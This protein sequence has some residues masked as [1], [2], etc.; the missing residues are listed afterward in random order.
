MRADPSTWVVIPSRLNSTRLPQKALHL[1]AGKP[2]IVRVVE[3]ALQSRR[4]EKVIVA[5]DH[6][7][8]V[9]AVQKFVSGHRVECVL[10][11]PE[12]PSGTDR[13]LHAVL[14]FPQAEQPQRVLNIQGDEPLI[15]GVFIDEL[16][17]AWDLRADVSLLTTARPFA[18]VADIQNPNMVK[19]LL[20]SRSEAIYFSRFPIPFSRNQPISGQT[21][22]NPLHH[23]GIYGF[24]IEFLKKFCSVGVS[25]IEQ[26]ESLEQLRALQMG[27]SIYVHLTNR[28]L[29]GVDT[30]DDVKRVEAY[31]SK[32]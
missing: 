17:E 25:S 8:I 4:A 5:T 10:T 7:S 9:D 21:L 26:S 3:G 20:N 22:I 1:I 30:L 14:Q 16:I 2:L 31:F 12:L 6:V 29:I 19:V 23:I 11:P 28:N 15:E 27:S 24:Q 18:D 32:K 13:C